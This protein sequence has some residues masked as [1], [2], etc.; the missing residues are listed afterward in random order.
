MPVGIDEPPHSVDLFDA[1]KPRRLRL[2]LR[3][4]AKAIAV[5]HRRFSEGILL[6]APGLGQV[7]ESPRLA[8]PVVRD[9]LAEFVHEQFRL[10][11]G[12]AGRFLRERDGAE[13]QPR[14]ADGIAHR[15]AERVHLIDR[16]D[17]AGAD[18]H[19]IRAAELVRDRRKVEAAGRRFGK[20]RQRNRR[21]HER[22][23]K[24]M[25]PL[26]DDAPRRVQLQFDP[27]WRGGPELEH[28][29]LVA[30]PVGRQRRIEFRQGPAFRHRAVALEDELDGAGLRH[31]SQ[32]PPPP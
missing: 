23:L 11:H 28:E 32:H 25:Q 14:R 22:I 12:V 10:Q 27:L 19:E 4:S 15:H 1:E 13:F 6:G 30:R 5:G 24:R 29:K 17:A 8:G 18:V 7:G 20:V 9:P 2:R 16:A 26:G 21:A 3:E 31:R